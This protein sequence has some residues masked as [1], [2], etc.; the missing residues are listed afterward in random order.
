M[1]IDCETQINIILLGG[2]YLAWLIVQT[3]PKTPKT[4]ASIILAALNLASIPLF[5]I[6]SHYEH[7]RSL[8][9]ST[10]F[11]FYLLISP[12]FDAAR[13]RTLWAISHDRSV[14]Y[15]TVAVVCL[16]FWLLLFENMDKKHFLRPEYADTAAEAMGGIFS[17]GLFWWLNPLLLKGFKSVL[18]IDGLDEIDDALLSDE[19]RAS[20]LQLKW[21]RC[22]YYKSSLT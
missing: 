22:A 14:A 19:M 18:I 3:E 17:R 20:S 7:M 13:A 21:R 12:L 4:K 10:L 16:K 5:A 1:S 9:P 8:R 11:S 15:I 2:L 6:L